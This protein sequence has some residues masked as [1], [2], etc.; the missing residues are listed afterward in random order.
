[1][2]NNIDVE[3]TQHECR[4]CNSF[5]RRKNMNM[6]FPRLCQFTPMYK[7]GKQDES[8]CN[9]GAFIHLLI[10]IDHQ[11]VTFVFFSFSDVAPGAV[12]H[13]Q[14]FGCF[15]FDFSWQ[16]QYLTLCKIKNRITH[17][18]FHFELSFCHFPW[19]AESVVNLQ[20]T[21]FFWRQFTKFCPFSWRETFSSAVN[22]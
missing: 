5:S 15:G 6:N 9:W 20:H 3:F 11:V 17:V 16:A 21:T 19:C 13:G 1:M 7:Q 22:D 18:L 12:W 2:E 10:G 14:C 4:Q 8:S